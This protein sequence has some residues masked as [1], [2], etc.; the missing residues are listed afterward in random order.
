M[1]EKTFIIRP[2]VEIELCEEDIENIVVTALEGGINY[3]ACLETEPWFVEGQGP[4]S[5]Q[6]T[7]RLLNGKSIRFYDAE[8]MTTGDDWVLTLDKLLAGIKQELES[9]ARNLSD[10]EFDAANADCIIQYALFGELVFG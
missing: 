4:V 6:V 2:I 8:D 3:W 1:N 5:T 9:E 10:I 7:Q